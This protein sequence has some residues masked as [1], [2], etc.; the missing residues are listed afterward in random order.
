MA[1]KRAKQERRP[2]WWPTKAQK[3]RADAAHREAMTAREIIAQA[4]EVE[5]TTDPDES[6]SSRFERCS[7]R[8]LALALVTIIGHGLQD[9]YGWDSN[10]AAWDRVG[11]WLVAQT[12]DGFYVVEEFV[13]DAEAHAKLKEI[14]RPC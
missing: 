2:P 14:C 12:D 10:D 6:E 5:P 1:A 9:A 3:E 13:S 7:D 8:P 4:V 11:R